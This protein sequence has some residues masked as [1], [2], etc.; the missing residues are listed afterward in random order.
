MSEFGKHAWIY[1]IGGTGDSQQFACRRTSDQLDQRSMP[2]VPG[3]ATQWTIDITPRGGRIGGSLR[4]TLPRRG[5]IPQ[6]RVA[7]SAHP[8][9]TGL[10]FDSYPE[11]VGQTRSHRCLVQPLRG[12]RTGAIRDPGCAARPWAVEYNPFGVRTRPAI[13]SPPPT[14]TSP[15]EGRQSADRAIASQDQPLASADESLALAD[16]PPPA[17]VDP[18]PEV[19]DSPPSG[20]DSPPAGGDPPPAGNESPPSGNDSPPSGND[21]PPAG[22]DPPPSGNDPPPP[23]GRSRSTVGNRLYVSIR[24]FSMALD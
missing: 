17:G 20:D 7:A 18:P 11:G 5:S 3:L 24:G 23:G 4:Q 21:P 2:V 8:G 14:L 22:D 19:D 6:P 12:R 1:P 16:H 15:R 9:E 10:C 13:N